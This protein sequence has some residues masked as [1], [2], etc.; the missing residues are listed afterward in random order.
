MV[1]QT[2]PSLYFTLIKSGNQDFLTRGLIVVAVV[3][4]YTIFIKKIGVGLDDLVFETPIY[5][6]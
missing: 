3:H 6:H 1:F 2:K 5:G 4:S